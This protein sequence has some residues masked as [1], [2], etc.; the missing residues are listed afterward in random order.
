MHF[1]ASSYLAYDVIDTYGQMLSLRCESVVSFFCQRKQALEGNSL[2]SSPSECFS[3]PNPE[4]LIEPYRFFHFPFHQ[5]SW[6][7]RSCMSVGGG[8][9]K[10]RITWVCGKDWE[11]DFPRSK[12]RFQQIKIQNSTLMS[13]VLWVAGRGNPVD[14][15]C[16]FSARSWGQ[17]DRLHLLQEVGTPPDLLHK[18]SSVCRV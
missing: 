9:S 12:I 16:R 3:L 13:H 6:G 15:T 10:V 7:Q 17:T 2:I 5:F 1:G 14:R 18:V 4:I 11:S 8:F